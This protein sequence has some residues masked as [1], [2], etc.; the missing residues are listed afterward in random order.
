MDEKSIHMA[1]D[2]ILADEC[3]KLR[4]AKMF[5]SVTNNFSWR[6]KTSINKFF[7]K[8]YTILE[9]LASRL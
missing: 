4:V 9:S 3:I 1:I 6:A 7:K 2:S 5:P 8:I